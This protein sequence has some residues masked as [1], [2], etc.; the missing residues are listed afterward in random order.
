[1]AKFCPPLHKGG[2]VPPE[3]KR[4]CAICGSMGDADDSDISSQAPDH[5]HSLASFSTYLP[6]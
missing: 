4:C 1:M 5:I 2:T 6:Y 3:D